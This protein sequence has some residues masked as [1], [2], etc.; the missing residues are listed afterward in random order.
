MIFLVCLSFLYT[1][2]FQMNANAS[3]KYPTM[4]DSPLIKKHVNMNHLY[5]FD[6]RIHIYARHIAGSNTFR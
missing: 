3:V 4:Y 2:E 5:V 6:I 1:F